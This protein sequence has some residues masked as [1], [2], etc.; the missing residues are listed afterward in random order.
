MRWSWKVLGWLAVGVQ[1]VA[2]AADNNDSLPSTP[3]DASVPS[4]DARV[5]VP[6]AQA[7]F[8][9]AQP[10][11]VTER[12]SAGDST[13][14]SE[15]DPA[16][17]SVSDGSAS[18]TTDAAD[19]T[20]EA[21]SGVVDEPEAGAD[22]NGP[23][24][25]DDAGE[26]PATAKAIVLGTT[27]TSM[28]CPGDIDFFAFTP[29]VGHAYRFTIEAGKFP[30]YL[31]VDLW[32][33]GNPP[34]PDITLKPADSNKVIFDKR[35]DQTGPYFLRV[36]EAIAGAA[37]KPNLT[38]EYAVTV[39]DLGVVADAEGDTPSTGKDIVV[40]T[41]TDGT[42]D[43]DND[44]DCFKFE[45]KAGHIY[46]ILGS[47]KDGLKLGGSIFDN[48]NAPENGF[49]DTVSAKESVFKVTEK[50]Q[51]A[52]TYAVRVFSNPPT[53]RGSYTVE[54]KD[55]GD[56]DAGDMTNQARAIAVGTAI[57]ARIQWHSPLICDTDVEEC[58]G[59][60]DVFSF[61]Y[62]RGKV[63]RAS[64]RS[65]ASLPLTASLW[66]SPAATAQVAQGSDATL[67]LKAPL[68]ENGPAIVKIRSGSE[69]PVPLSDYTLLVEEVSGAVDVGDVY[70]DATTV[71]I[72]AEV[73]GTIDKAFDNDWFNFPVEA[74]GIYRISVTGTAP[75]SSGGP[76]LYLHDNP[77]AT[78]KVSGSV[79]STGA[80]TLG[81]KFAATGTA[82]LR[83]RASSSSVGDYTLKIEAIK[84]DHPDESNAASEMVIGA[85][86]DGYIDYPSDSDWLRFDYQ[87]PVPVTMN[88]VATGIDT[89]LDSLDP[90]GNAYGTDIG[91]GTTSY[92]INSVGTYRI[93]IRSR[94]VDT[95]KVKLV[96]AYTIVMK[97]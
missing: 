83:L 79:D 69:H 34:A 80:R 31:D 33:P 81:W 51:Y 14:G 66:P 88:L 13:G 91:P 93:R 1:L 62:T 59:D 40:G 97:P 95:N 4:S 94:S 25:K 10:Q 17:A 68:L 71:A 49:M 28:D 63:Y 87:G 60:T 9:D 6:D 2:C 30:G 41:P 92:Q 21:G 29:T 19:A 7:P 65:K 54:V 20:Q 76:T 74:N 26:E 64:I 85:V 36:R 86:V 43:L 15:V 12:D 32:V 84:N 58:V 77:N 78:P 45:V 72:G 90:S 50:F 53:A 56:D 52:G 11:K 55:L 38:G 22:P 89:T 27:Q 61:P 75:G 5:V 8:V 96:G 39:E 16:D 23:S 35:L 37:A 57:D 44:K 47:A 67:E 70:T 46:E 42:F 48:L 18:G 82:Y 73:K 3:L 24:C